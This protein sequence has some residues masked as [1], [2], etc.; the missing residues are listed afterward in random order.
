MVQADLLLGAV[1]VPSADPPLT[2]MVVAHHLAAA[3]LLAAQ[4]CMT[5]VDAHV[6]AADKVAHIR[7]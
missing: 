4:L 6:P 5:S 2:C 7:R 1:P 3:I